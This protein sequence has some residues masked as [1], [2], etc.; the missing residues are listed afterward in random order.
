MVSSYDFQQENVC[1]RFRYSFASDAM[2]AMAKISK[3]V[4]VGMSMFARNLKAALHHESRCTTRRRDR[5][6]TGA[7]D[8]P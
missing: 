2:Q 4:L 8:C 5:V 6:Q 1:K 7:L 3:R